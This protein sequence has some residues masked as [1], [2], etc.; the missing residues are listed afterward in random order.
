MCLG[1]S[2]SAALTGLELPAIDHADLELLAVL[3]PLHS[4]YMHTLLPKGRNFGEEIVGK[5]EL[6]MESR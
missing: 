4:S 6:K 2:H 5:Q 1:E 3:L